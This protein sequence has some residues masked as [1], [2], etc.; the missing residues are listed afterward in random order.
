MSLEDIRRDRGKKTG[1]AV[2]LSIST[3]LLLMT[4]FSVGAWLGP[5]PLR[6]PELIAGGVFA[7]FVGFFVGLSVG[8]RRIEAEAKVALTVKERGRKRHL[9]IFSDYFTLD[10]KIVPRTRLRAAT[11]TEDRLELAILEDDDSTT[12]CALFGP[13]NDLARARMAL[14]LED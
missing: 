4:S 11:L 6:V 14:A 5:G 12:R 7:A 1:S 9:A 10:G 2:A 13:P 3:S 8:Q